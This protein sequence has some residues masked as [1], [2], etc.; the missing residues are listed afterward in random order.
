MVPI[1]RLNRIDALCQQHE[2][3]LKLESCNPGGSI[4]EKNAIYLIQLAEEKG[5]LKPGGTIIESS[6]GNFGLGLAIV[7]AAKGYRVVIIID[8]K[9]SQTMR[10][11]LSTY[12][13]EL[14]EVPATAADAHGSMQVARMEA[15]DHLAAQ[16]PGGWYVCQHK[17]PHNPEAHTLTT[18]REIEA[19]FDG[20]PDAIVVGISTA[21]QLAGLAQFFRSRYPKTRLVG[22]DVAGSAIFGTPRHAYKMT[23]LGLSFVPPNFTPDMLDAAYLVEDR[24]AFSLCHALAK[25]EGMMLGGST[26]AIVAAALADVRQFER[27]QRVVMLNPDRGDRYLDTLYDPDWLAQQN[28][29]LFQDDDLQEAIYSLSAVPRFNQRSTLDDHP[30]FA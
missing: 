24:L 23:G 12:G 15:A 6:S 25:R 3:Y 16:T 13:A 19:A 22:V 29:T 26:G 30:T 9:T 17:N 1:V 7:G 5:W 4:K 10:R 2:L 18:A 11:M 20:A 27:P 28:I 14:V 8:A 21:G